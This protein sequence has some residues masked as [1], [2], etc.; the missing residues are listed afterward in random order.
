M[1]NLAEAHRMLAT[2]ATSARRALM[3]RSSTSREPSAAFAR[4]NR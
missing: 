3:S 4:G 1:F 2:F